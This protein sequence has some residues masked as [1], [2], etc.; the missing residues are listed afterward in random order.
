MRY[1]YLLADGT[2]A[3]PEPLDVLVSMV[4]DGRISLNTLVAPAGGEDWTPL[5]RVLRYFYANATGATAGP[6]AFSELNRMH[7]VEALADDA[8]VM[9]EGG[10]E[11]RTLAA[12]LGAGGVEVV[13]RAV[14]HQRPA[15]WRPPP[16]GRGRK[17]GTGANP[18]A[19]SRVGQKAISRYP[20]GGIGRLE[21]FSFSG[22]LL[23]VLIGGLTVIT[24]K[25]FTIIWNLVHFHEV[26]RDEIIRIWER[27]QTVL[28]LLAGIVLMGGLVLMLLRIRN[29]GWRWYFLFLIFVPLVQFWFFIAL[30]AYP[31]GYARHGRLDP[32]SKAI[33]GMVAGLLVL[34]LLM[35]MLFG[36]RT[37]TPATTPAAPAAP[38][39]IFLCIR[40]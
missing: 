33:A 39:I 9:E 2:T 22:L 10:V 14:A 37:E 23:A 5:A 20:A 17:R 27:N 11:W 28:I 8:W 36:K 7:Q 15:A 38:A 19:A 35:F 18:Y 26:D 25:L 16:A 13:P 34:M 4:A 3:G 21:Y 30:L 12:A 1:F 32:A 29:I 40:Q 31:P 24:S 6:V